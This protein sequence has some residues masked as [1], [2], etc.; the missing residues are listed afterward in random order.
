MAVLIDG[1]ELAKKTRQ[2][3]KIDCE[4]LKKKR[5]KSKACSY[6]GWR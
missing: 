6:N 1:K 3:L 4:N 2:N 5:N